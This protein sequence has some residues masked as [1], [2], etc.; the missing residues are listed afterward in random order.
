MPAPVPATTSTTATSTDTTST[1][2]TSA[3]ATARPVPI[4][5]WLVAGLLTVLPLVSCSGAIYFTFVY[6][7]G[8]SLAVGLPFVAVFVA[9]SATGVAAGVGVVRGFAVAWRAAIGYAVAMSLWTVAKLVFWHELEALAFGAAGLAVAALLATPAVRAHVA[10]P[11]P[12]V[13]T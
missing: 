5:V 12:G 8:T 2:A 10:V 11:A 13:A 3:P 9:I 4:P 7:G 1:T 6:E